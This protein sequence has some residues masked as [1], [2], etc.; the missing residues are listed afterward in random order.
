M[1]SDATMLVVATLVDA[2]EVVCEEEGTRDS[3]CDPRTP[4]A[5]PKTLPLILSLIPLRGNF[6][7]C[8]Q[9]VEKLTVQCFN[10]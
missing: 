5:V 4:H 7:N 1:S 10:L 3:S 2:Q 6:P 8:V 9:K